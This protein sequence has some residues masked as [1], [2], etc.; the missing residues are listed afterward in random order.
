MEVGVAAGEPNAK[1]EHLLQLVTYE[2]ASALPVLMLKIEVVALCFKLKY[3][4]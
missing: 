1:K 2:F 3:S 4:R